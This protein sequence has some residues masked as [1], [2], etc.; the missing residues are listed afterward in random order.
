M[1]FDKKLGRPGS[2]IGALAAITGLGV[3]ALATIVWIAFAAAQ[4]VGYHMDAT[5]Q[6]ARNVSV[7]VSLAG[8]LGF[9]CARTLGKT[10]P[11]RAQWRAIED[12]VVSLRAY[13]EPTIGHVVDLGLQVELLVELVTKVVSAEIAKA[14]TVVHDDQYDPRPAPDPRQF[15]DEEY[16]ALMA[17]PVDADNSH[18]NRYPKERAGGRTPTIRNTMDD[19]PVTRPALRDVKLDANNMPDGPSYPIKEQLKHHEDIADPEAVEE[20]ADCD[21]TGEVMEAYSNGKG[22]HCERDI[23]CPTCGGD[24]FTPAPPVKPPTQMLGSATYGVT[25]G[26]QSALGQPGSVENANGSEVWPPKAQLASLTDDE[27]EEWVRRQRPDQ[28]LEASAY[29][30]GARQWRDHN[31]F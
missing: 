11:Q 28:L 23:P 7:L 19:I 1:S 12:E 17:A 18:W 31:Q 13:L 9:A 15:S 26:D 29:A 25:L 14:D 3:I 16:N 24:G 21:G 22:A 27:L 4:W 6:A 20:C 8:Y 30:E 10:E 2:V 5:D